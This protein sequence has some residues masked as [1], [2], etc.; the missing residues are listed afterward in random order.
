[1]SRQLKLTPAAAQRVAE[2]VGYK[3]NINSPKEFG[4]F[5]QKNPDA[6]KLIRHY[7]QQAKHMAA[8]A[9]GLIPVR[10]YDKGG[11]QP[12][13]YPAWLR[14]ALNPNTPTTKDNESM[15]TASEY[16]EKLGGEALY[17][18]IR[19]SE[20]GTLRKSN[21]DEA[22]EKGD[23]ILVS[24]GNNEATREAATM[25]SKQLVIWLMRQDDQNS[26]QSNIKQEVSYL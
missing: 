11:L 19:M 25:L 22:I 26:S 20:E 2:Q 15:R 9:G 1:M 8:A 24:G 16:S 12:D 23:Y 5:L 10:K 13:K 18:T 21:F 6:G 7:Q 17:P 14:R 4:K 3:G